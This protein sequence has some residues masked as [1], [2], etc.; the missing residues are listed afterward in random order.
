MGL[1][2][3][4][5]ASGACQQRSLEV[6]VYDATFLFIRFPLVVPVVPLVVPPTLAPGPRSHAPPQQNRARLGVCCSFA[7]TALI[8]ASSASA[9]LKP[10]FNDIAGGIDHVNDNTN[11][12][13]VIPG[14]NDGSST[15]LVA[16]TECSSEAW[17]ASYKKSESAYVYAG[18]PPSMRA[19]WRPHG[20][21]AD[22]G[23]MQFTMC[24]M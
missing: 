11:G 6:S 22:S 3:Q 15:L 14:A 5:F 21:T 19:T 7:A 10:S 13:H 12:R 4:V 24:S 2:V 18:P 17:A 20:C 1:N 8:A 9:L 16:G 23:S